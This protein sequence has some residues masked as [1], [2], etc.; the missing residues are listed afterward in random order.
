MTETVCRA[1]GRSATYRLEGGVVSVT[2]DAGTRTFDLGQ[3]RSARLATLGGMTI[4]ELGLADGSVRTIVNED[5]AL[6]E[7]WSSLVR[8]V[9]ADLASG[10]NVAFVS[11]SWMISGVIATITGIVIAAAAVIA[12]GAITLPSGLEGRG[13]LLIALACVS[14]I[15]G[16]AL[17]WRSR[18]R[19]YDPRSP[20]LG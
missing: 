6:R 15:A 10:G 2:D 3:V 7:G 11:G 9:H 13:T 19:R 16:P 14:A 4:C 8:A 1:L 18:P 5:P 17:A 20:P 12:S